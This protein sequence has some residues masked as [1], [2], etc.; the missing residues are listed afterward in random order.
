MPPNR[1]R[2]QALKKSVEGWQWIGQA[3]LSLI[4]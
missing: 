1:R 4:E 2:A 3:N